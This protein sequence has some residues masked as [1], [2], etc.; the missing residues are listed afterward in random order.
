MPRLPVLNKRDLVSPEVQP[1]FDAIMENRGAVTTPVG[2][3][4]HAP[5]TARHAANLGAYLRF[6]SGL[7]ND[8]FELAVITAAREFDC[9]FVWAAHAETAIREGVPQE[10]VDAIG[11]RGDVEAFPSR[12]RTVAQF[13]REMVNVHRVSQATLEAVRAEFGER[14][15]TDITALVGFYLMLACTL[16]ANAMELPAGRAGFPPPTK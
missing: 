15:L 3:L 14:G 2:L 10:L 4:M 13:T 8:I 1:V 7:S 5:E 6:E 11:V 9:E 12:Y 16:F